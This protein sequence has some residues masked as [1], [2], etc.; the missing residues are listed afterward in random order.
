M[1]LLKKAKEG[2]ILV[3]NSGSSSLKL[4]LF[5]WEKTQP[6]ALHL[7]ATALAEEL[8]SSPIHLR[9]DTPSGQGSFQK[10]ISSL[11]E[12]NRLK[13]LL[14]LL[15][16]HEPCFAPEKLTAVGHRVVHGGT[17]THSVLVDAPLLKQLEELI[18]LAPLHNPA[19]IKG[20]QNAM[21]ATGPKIPHIAVFDTAFHR[22]LA[23]CARYYG[24]PYAL[25][26]QH[27]IERYGFHG[28]AHK[29]LWE[30]YA[31]K[32]APSK[33]TPRKIITLHLGNGCSI[34]AI[35]EGLSQE[36]SMGY[37]PAEG[38]L[39]GTR[40]GNIDAGAVEALCRLEGCSIQQILTVLNEQSGL[41]GVSGIASDLRCL[42]KEAKHSERAKLALDLF[43]HRIRLYIGAYL[44][45]LEGAD[46]L[47]FS[48]GIGENSGWVRKTVL[49]GMQWCGIHL[50][51]VHNDVT[52]PI[53]AGEV[54]PLHE[55]GSKV[56]LYAVGAD[57]NRAIAKEVV[58]V[59]TKNE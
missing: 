25:T 40:A 45:I 54:R 16:Q 19:A 41:L 35:N 27:H 14:Q 34:T 57:E 56:A 39:M 4:S 17:H 29:A 58:R 23:P 46:A 30:V 59:L 12:S 3:V 15:A 6:P 48:G 31:E 52:Y 21:E 22:S 36:T 20:I 18:P 8:H 42:L 1:A 26:K 33:A 24:I 9:Y 43:C 28:I 47:I 55:E 44:A 32:I 53:L 50:D 7:C 37:T 13:A 49:S 10:D 38:L 51:H 2:A 5:Q 11:D